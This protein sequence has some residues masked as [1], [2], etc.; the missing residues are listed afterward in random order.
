LIEGGAQPFNTPVYESSM[1]LTGVTYG[2]GDIERIE[3]PDPAQ[4]GQFVEAGQIR[5][6]TERPTTT[7]EGRFAQDLL[8]DL[9]RIA[10]KGCAVD[11]QCHIGACSDPRV[12][13]KF[14][15]AVI[16][17]GA[18]ITSYETDEL[19][20]LESGANAVVNESAPLSAVKM[21]DVTPVS[22]GVK[23][24][25]VLTNE[26]V[27]VVICDA[28]ACGEC[29]EESDGCQK[30]FAV[31]IA[32][33]GS[34]STP[35][36]IVY[37]ID[38]GVNWFAH[39]VDTLGVAEAADDVFCLGDYVV[40]ISDDSDS[41]HIALK[42]QF[43]GFTDPSF[44]E[45]TTGFVATKGPRAAWV[46]D[47]V[48]FLV[49]EGGYIYS[50][51]NPA[52]GV[53]V[54]DAGSSTTATLND[55]HAISSTFAVAVGDNGVIVK[56]ENGTTWALAD[57]SPV[58]YGVNINC[59]WVRSE[60]VWLV[61]TAGGDLFY[62]KNGGKTWTEITI[63]ASTPTAVTDIYF[64]TDSIGYVAFTEGGRGKIARTFNGGATW[65]ITPEGG[66][67]LPDNDRINALTGCEFDP[68]FIVGAGLAG[69][70]A[71]GFIVVGAGV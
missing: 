1:R 39:D 36:D 46:A 40:V 3:V 44:S 47:G 43:D 56:T 15:K 4:Y 26:V 9:L 37:S 34:P 21:Y 42:S 27:A 12:F 25:N 71:D 18:T 54:L 16:F 52:A 68:N 61:G 64:P 70:G 6:A 28:V 65:V 60:T 58:G 17:E 51:T 57:A 2:F 22:Y 41:A 30:I 11:V 14:D 62:T 38:K 45:A 63:A 29:A 10:R 66:S 49:G 50:M 55:V 33:G 7:L 31:T 24:S 13:E 5:G 23:A 8:S 53:T 32:A 59:V 48:A 20:A 69:D 67:S 19:G 35:S